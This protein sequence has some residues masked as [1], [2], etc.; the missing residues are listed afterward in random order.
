MDIA[1]KSSSNARGYFIRKFVHY[2]TPIFIKIIFYRESK[3]FS[4]PNTHSI[5]MPVSF[6]KI[7]G[8]TRRTI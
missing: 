7:G 3:M 4:I 1:V 6:C 2:S 5:F 8:Y